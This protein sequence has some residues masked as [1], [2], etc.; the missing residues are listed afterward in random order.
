MKVNK[1]QSIK[2]SIR[3]KTELPKITPKETF[4]ES[5]TLARATVFTS[6]WHKE[7]NKVNQPEENIEKVYTRESYQK[8]QNTPSLRRKS[9]PIRK[10]FVTLLFVSILIAIS[11]FSINFFEK[12][13]IV[14]VAKQQSFSLEHKEFQASKEINAPIYF[15]IMIVPGETIEKIVLTETQ[16]VSLKAKGEVTLYNEYSTKPQKLQAGTFLADT[17]GKA[18]KI[19]KTVTIPG[20][21]KNNKIIPGQVSVGVTAFL[22]GES[23]NGKPTDFT[24]TSFKNTDK[25]KSI[26]AK[27]K[28]PLVG[29]AQGVIYTPGPEEIGGLNAIASSSFKAS[30]LKKVYAE[31]PKGYILYPNAL[32]FSY[33]IDTTSM[34]PTPNANV[35]INGLV[36]ALLL[37]ESDITITVIKSMIPNIKPDEL[38]EIELLNLDK[39]SFNFVNENQVISKDIK[40]IPFNLTGNLDMLWHPNIDIF[41]SSFIGIP[42]D[43]TLPLFKSD[44]G[45]TNATVTL[46]PPWQSHLPYDGSKI[47]FT[48]Q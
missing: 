21:T 39:L 37:K 9:P 27:G 22:P 28:T 4:T 14:I 20:F 8:M 29:G 45:I 23:Y 32:T 44:P 7:E 5:E 10:S 47:Q 18:Y 46:F 34:S 40:I 41:K 3:N 16:D 2:P 31:L 35:K 48:I 33:N 6:G 12:A 26:Y 11:Y 36:S 13:K 38:K 43:S 25:Y 17:D 15:E 24:I 42:K 19:D 1:I 30:L